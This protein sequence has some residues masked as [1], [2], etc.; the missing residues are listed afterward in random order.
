MARELAEHSI[1]WMVERELSE[2]DACR[3]MAVAAAH[4]HYSI[5]GAGVG[6]AKMRA[7]IDSCEIEERRAVG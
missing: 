5:Y 3:V 7:T 1:G 6:L 2:G 4:V